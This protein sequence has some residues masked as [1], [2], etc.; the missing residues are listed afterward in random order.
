[1]VHCR[2]CN[3]EVSD[4]AKFCPKCRTPLKS[5]EDVPKSPKIA[6]DK[7]GGFNPIL[8]IGII[9]IVAIAALGAGLLLGGGSDDSPAAVN[10]TAESDDVAE[11]VNPAPASANVTYV[12]SQKSDKFHLPDCEWAQKINPKNK[13]TNNSRDAAVADGRIPCQVCNP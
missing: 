8:I 3:S 5:N 2:E 1:M 4:K 10:N 11:D 9:A 7:K 6:S 12:C 13:I